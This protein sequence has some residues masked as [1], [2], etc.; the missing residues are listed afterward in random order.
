[1][2]WP[3]LEPVSELD[4]PDYYQIIKEPMGKSSQKLYSLIFDQL[5]H[6][7]DGQEKPSTVYS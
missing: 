1:M 5:I 2:A 3:F 4:A 6:I 7:V